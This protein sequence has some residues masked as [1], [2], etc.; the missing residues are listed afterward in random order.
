MLDHYRDL[1]DVV[2]PHLRDRPF[3]MLRYPDGIAGKRFFQKDAPSHTPGWVKLAPLPAGGRTIR[4]P[5]LQDELSL[6]WAIGMGCIDLNVWCA[7]ADKPE[8]PD[9]VIFDLD[10]AP[11]AGFDEARQVALLVR[12]VLDSVGLRAYPR[13][14]GSQRG[15]HVLVPIAR[16]HTHAEAREIVAAVAGLLAADH[17]GLVTSAW[18]KT[19]RRG[20]LI[21][22]NQNGYGR[23][24][25]W[26]YSVRPREGALVA[27]PVTWEELAEPLDPNAFTMEVVHQRVARLGDLHRP[28]LEDAQSLGKALKA[29]G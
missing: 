17:P 24:T 20:V 18:A 15:L 7:R 29:L 19:E 13:T 2:L 26:A 5:L 14:S 22:A 16:R 9:A 10:P 8:R 21:D 12:E 3:T 25:A 28:V 27:T 23:T 11:P 1:A 6:L 4:F